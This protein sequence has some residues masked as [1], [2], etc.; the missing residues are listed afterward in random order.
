LHS[1]NDKGKIPLGFVC[2]LAFFY[3]LVKQ[4]FYWEGL[5]PTLKDASPLLASEA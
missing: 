5:I 3:R 4:K 2:L 1:E